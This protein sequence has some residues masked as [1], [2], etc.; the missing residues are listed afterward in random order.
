MKNTRTAIDNLEGHIQLVQR[1]SKRKASSSDY[2][3]ENM[4]YILEDL[5]SALNIRSIA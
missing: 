2:S 3:V 5:G 1:F 4:G